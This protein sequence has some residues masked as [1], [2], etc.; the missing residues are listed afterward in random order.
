MILCSEEKRHE[1]LR[2]FELAFSRVK[3]VEC[4]FC[5]EIETNNYFCFFNHKKP[6]ELSYVN[7]GIYDVARIGIRCSLFNP[8]NPTDFPH[9]LKYKKLLQEWKE[10][11]E[12]LINGTGTE[13]AGR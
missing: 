4:S 9:Y 6:V 1:L 5:R 12:K 3:C 10:E 8:N 11:E 2:E 7:F 13:D